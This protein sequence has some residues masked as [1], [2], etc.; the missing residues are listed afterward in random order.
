MLQALEETD[1]KGSRA[2]AL[3]LDLP[4]F[5]AMNPPCRNSEPPSTPDGWAEVVE[6]VAGLDPDDMTPKE[7]L[8]ALYT[9]R[10]LHRMEVK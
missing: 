6:A 5:A 7:A 4:L 9:L 3:G 10:A 2:E 8:D 1:A